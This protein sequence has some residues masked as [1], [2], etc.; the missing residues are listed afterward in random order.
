MTGLILFHHL[1]IRMILT[2][3]TILHFHVY[4][5]QLITYP[6][7]KLVAKLNKFL[8]IQVLCSKMVGLEEAYIQSFRKCGRVVFVEKDVQEIPVFKQ[9]ET[10]ERGKHPED[11]QLSSILDGCTCRKK[12]EKKKMFKMHFS[13]YHPQRYISFSFA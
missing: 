10:Q 7:M 11:I 9:S 6:L 5:P 13:S 2:I 12:K 8:R 3:N 4:S 1:N